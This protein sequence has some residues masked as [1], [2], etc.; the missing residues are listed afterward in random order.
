MIKFISFLTLLILVNLNH[1]VVSY[2]EDL[3]NQN[4]KKNNTDFDI[5][6][7]VF[8]TGSSPFNLTYADWTAK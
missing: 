5:S 8:E 2:S 7:L 1:I 4:T 3:S 6:N